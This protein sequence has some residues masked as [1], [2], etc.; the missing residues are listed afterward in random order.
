MAGGFPQASLKIVL[1]GSGRADADVDEDEEFQLDSNQQFQT[2]DRSRQVLGR[3]SRMCIY[4]GDPG[5]PLWSRKLSDIM[6]KKS[7]TKS[8]PDKVIAATTAGMGGPIMPLSPGTARLRAAKV[9]P[10]NRDDQPPISVAVSRSS[11]L[12]NDVALLI[13][14]AGPRRRYSCCYALTLHRYTSLVVLYDWL[15]KRARHALRRA[16]CMGQ[17]LGPFEGC[18][19]RPLSRPPLDPLRICAGSVCSFVMF[20]TTAH[21]ALV[22]AAVSMAS[23][24]AAAVGS[25]PQFDR[26]TPGFLVTPSGQI[27]WNGE[28]DYL[29]KFAV[30]PGEWTTLELYQNYRGTMILFA[31][32]DEIVCVFPVA[33]P[34]ESA[35]VVLQGSRCT[36]E[37]NQKVSYD[38]TTGRVQWAGYPTGEI[39]LR[40]AVNG[41]FRPGPAPTAAPEASQLAARCLI[42]QQAVF[43]LNPTSTKPTE[44]VFPRANTSVVHFKPGPENYY[45]MTG[46]GFDRGER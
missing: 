33:P 1:F 22:V 44:L 3:G 17:A 26:Q 28:N 45:K 35:A 11:S 23:T 25:S 36:G 16:R 6:K 37:A 13:L 31:H 39:S 10:S 12:H 9:R 29:Y 4:A 2:S 41:V 30:A 42:M 15:G 21:L 14:I 19:L 18:S 40:A 20:S 24:L 43:Q 46:T 8:K 38:S 5:M 34:R 32:N 7:E 27:K